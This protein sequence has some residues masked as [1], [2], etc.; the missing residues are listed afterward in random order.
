LVA[1]AWDIDGINARYAD[2]LEQFRPE[3]KPH[4]EA[5][6]FREY[7]SVLHEYRKFLF[8]DPGLPLVLQPKGFLAL[9]A[10]ELFRSRK[11][12]LAPLVNAYVE[13]T[14]EALPLQ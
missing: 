10:A 4:G 1:R 14:F 2:F 12:H 13:R 9:E 7:V 3:P 11:A 5:E 6:A 8:L